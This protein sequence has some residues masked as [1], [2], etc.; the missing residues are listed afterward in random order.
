MIPVHQAE[1]VKKLEHTIHNVNE[2]GLETIIHFI[3]DMEKCELYN[4]NTTKERLEQIREEEQQ[5]EM[6]RKAQEEAE[7][8]NRAEAL[9]TNETMKLLG[10]Q[11][12]FSI[13]GE[14]G[15]KE[16]NNILKANPY[17]ATMETALDLFVLGHIYGKRAERAKRK[18][19]CNVKYKKEIIQMLNEMSNEE[20][21]EKIYYYVNA[22][23]QRDKNKGV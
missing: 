20:Y 12:Y 11:Y 5:A 19:K 2:K 22:K 16:I 21:L 7:R 10:Y 13:I 14:K 4:I 18:D 1:L 23:Y 6:E 17:T 15:F 3:G 8:R 9:K